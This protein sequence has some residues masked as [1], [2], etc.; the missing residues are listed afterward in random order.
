MDY[1]IVD[2]KTDGTILLQYTIETLQKVAKTS[3]S[4]KG[5]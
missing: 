2:A 1:R 3:V 4:I 5:Q